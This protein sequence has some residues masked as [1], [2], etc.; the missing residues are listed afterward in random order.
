MAGERSG[1]TTG[2]RLGSLYALG[3]AGDLTDGQLLERFL[4]RDDP[5]ASEAAFAELV[6]RHG[7]L[8]QAI[9]RR[10]L[11]DPNDASD[12]FQATFLVLVSKARALR[13]WET[14]GGWLVGIAR[15]VSARARVESARRRK[16]LE[17]LGVERAQSGNLGSTSPII[18]D[19]PDHGPLIAEVARLPERFRAP[20]VLH[21]FEGLSTEAT[22]QRLGCA[23]GTVLSRLS[24]ARSRLKQRLEDRGAAP[25]LLV[26]IGDAVPRWL[27]IEPVPSSLAQATVR[28]AGALGLA[29]ASVESAVP[30]AVARLSRRVA[31]TLSLARAAALASIVV[32][33]A[34]GVSIGLAAG[35]QT[36]GAPQRGEMMKKAREGGVKAPASSGKNDAKPGET[37]AVRGRVLD[38]DG[39]PLGGAQVFLSEPEVGLTGEPQRLG[40]TGPDGGFDVRIPKSALSP[41]L[42]RPEG[43]NVLATVVA[44][45]P[46]LGPDWAQV[47]AKRVSQPITLRLRP[48]DVPVEGRIINLE[49][50][51]AEGVSARVAAV[52]E[53]PAELLERLRKNAGAQN[54]SLWT[55]MRNVCSPGDKG[56]IPPATTGA[57]GRFRLS[58]I[59]RDRVVFLI[60][61][62]PAIE[63]TIAFAATSNDRNFQPVP[64]PSDGPMRITLQ[65]ARF[66]TSVAPGSTIRGTIRDRDTGQPVAGARVITWSEGSQPITSDARGQFRLTSQPRGRENYLTITVEDRP[67]IKVVK[68]ITNADGKAPVDVT[69]RRGVWIEGKVV[70]K[71]TG[72][73]V[74]AVVTYYPFRDNPH[75]K[76]CPD[77]SFLNNHLGDEVEFRTDAQG[78]FRAVGL[79]GGGILAVQVKEPGYLTAKPLDDRTAGNVLHAANFQYYM[80]PYH[81][82]VTLDVPNGKATSIPDI[83]LTAGREQHI[84]IVDPEAKPVTGA[85]ILCL[86]VGLLRESL[87]G[88]IIAGD[89]WSFTNSHP[90]KAESIIISHAGRS[91]GAMIELKGDEPDPVRVVLQPCGTVTGR[92]VDEE[93]KPRPGM[94]L[95]LGQRFRSAG[96][97]TGT[98]RQDGL[99]TDR[100]GRFRITTL[101]PGLRYD[102]VVLKKQ[103]VQ[104]YSDQAEG[105]LWKN[106]WTVKPG[107]TIELGDVQVKGA[108]Q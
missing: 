99:A 41:R 59:G 51:P 83:A 92:L 84:Q 62:G 77:A 95:R 16:H 2:G 104:N 76:E 105:G 10:E 106:E 87:T 80:T 20:V 26:A 102:L 5:I 22:A 90:G 27:P 91:L 12:A 39:K 6:D 103:F 36:A 108:P 3:A 30:T 73:P 46:G 54:P 11:G 97:W 40:T 28:S 98:D 71:S 58:G 48:D 100:D 61:E 93:G 101:V 75:V 81:A 79:P 66:E 18:A 68:T 13:D 49:G 25:G 37:V 38:P 70:N 1:G 107:E 55:D 34:A 53:F 82:L 9:C 31:R 45:S 56:L 33:A 8:V 4:T 24:R 72:K 86:Q 23:R 19:E 60:L 85:R 7:S 52:A 44:F 42:D 35:L 17:R 29:G 14:V 50:R 94:R 47:D 15:R 88:E 69:L 63:Q 21:Y 43:P 96:Q 57:D 67:Y 74:K 78:R 65:P 64:L 32:V 89:E